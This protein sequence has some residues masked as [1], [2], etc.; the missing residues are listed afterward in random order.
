MIIQILLYI[1][2]DAET[3]TR[4]G[5]GAI[6]GIIAIVV[7]GIITSM[8]SGSALNKLKKAIVEL[9]PVSSIM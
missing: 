2:L 6:V 5:V 7:V 1:L 9:C 4:I 3:S 8:Q